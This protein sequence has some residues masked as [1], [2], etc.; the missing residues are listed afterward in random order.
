M[1]E[2]ESK[3]MCFVKMSKRNVVG[4]ITEITPSIA[5]I[6]AILR[7]IPLCLLLAFHISIFAAIVISIPIG[8]TIA[9]EKMV[10]GYGLLGMFSAIISIPIAF[11][12]AECYMSPIFRKLDSIGVEKIEQEIGGKNYDQKLEKRYE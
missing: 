7:N 11:A 3:L 8:M 2:N 9:I 12:Y 10:G 4:T 5:T 6:N 1:S